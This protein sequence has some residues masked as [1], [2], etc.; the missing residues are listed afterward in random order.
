MKMLLKSFM[1]IVVLLAKVNAA[2]T[3]Q[4]GWKKFQIGINSMCFKILA[5]TE[6][7]R[8]QSICLAQNARL[9]LPKNNRE[10]SD[11]YKVMKALSAG[12][13]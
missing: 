11:L 5:Y 9:P 8:G 4:L 13:D 2:S 10:D 12:R 1:L 7:S 3:C 6:I